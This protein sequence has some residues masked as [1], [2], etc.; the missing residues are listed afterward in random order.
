[1]A[2]IRQQNCAR[3]STLFARRTQPLTLPPALARGALCR[4][5]K[6]LLD[7]SPLPINVNAFLTWKDDPNALK[8]AQ[9]ARA[10]SLITASAA[11]HRT[12]RDG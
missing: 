4:Y 12:M 8:N 5:D 6:Y 1:M 3:F 11:F 9:P 2:C 10:A 7:R